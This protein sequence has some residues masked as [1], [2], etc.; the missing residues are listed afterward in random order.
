[1]AIFNSY[2]QLPKSTCRELELHLAAFASFAL[3]GTLLKLT[4]IGHL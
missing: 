1:M 3:K 2:V 4:P